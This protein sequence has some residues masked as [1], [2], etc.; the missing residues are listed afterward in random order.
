MNDLSDTR[1]DAALTTF[2]AMLDGPNPPNVEQFL[3]RYPDIAEQLGPLLASIAAVQG[4]GRNCEPAEAL[5][6]GGQI[7]P[8]RLLREIGRGGMG[9]V[10][11]AED[12]AMPRRVAVKVVAAGLLDAASRAALL[13]E[14]RIA[15]VLQHPNIVP[16][17]AAGEVDGVA[18]IAMQYIDGRPLSAV[19]RA[20]RIDA[21]LESAV[22]ASTPADSSLLATGL[23]TGFGAQQAPSMVPTASVTVD[24]TYIREIAALGI[25]AAN[26]L[27]FV[28][29]NGVL[30][31]DAKPGNF[32]LDVRGHLWLSD[33]GLARAAMK[34]EETLGARVGTLRYASPEQSTGGPLDPRSDLYA[35][36]VTLYELLTL[37]PAFAGDDPRLLA[38][39]QDDEPVSLR[40]FA[41][42]VPVDLATVI[43]KAMAKR[44]YDRYPSAVALAADLNRFLC[45]EHVE[46]R[47]LSR[48][49]R[50]GRLAY[51]RRRPFALAIA[52]LFIGLSVAGI[53]AWRGYRSEAKARQE[54][55]NREA[56][57]RELV[58]EVNKSEAVFRHL[59]NGQPEHRRLVKVLKEVV[60]RWADEPNA[61]VET[62]TEAVRACLRLGQVEMNAGQNIEGGAT[63][64][65]A[66][67]RVSELRAVDPNSASLRFLHAQGLQ[68]RARVL[69]R[70]P[71]N[72][73]AGSLAAA[74][75]ATRLLEELIDEFPERTEYRNPIGHLAT[76]MANL[77]IDQKRYA[78]A[79]AMMEKALQSDQ[80][81][82]NR[83]PT[84]HP[85]SYIRLAGTWCG[86]AEARY[87]S[88]DL[89]GAE[90]AYREA[91]RNDQILCEPRF[92]YPRTNR[93][94]TFA[95]RGLFGRFLIGQ[96]RDADARPYIEEFA[97]EAE[98]FI[99]IYPDRFVF[100]QHAQ[101]AYLDLGTLEYLAGR[102]EEARRA[103]RKSL[104]FR[105]DQ[106]REEATTLALLSL[107][108]PLDDLRESEKIVKA[109][110][111]EIGHTTGVDYR[112]SRLRHAIGTRDLAGARSLRDDLINRAPKEPQDRLRFAF[113]QA[114]LAG[115]AGN[116]DVAK[117]H[118][119]EAERILQ[120]EPVPVNA[121]YRVLR[122]ETELL[123][124]KYAK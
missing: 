85:Q 40:L 2:A 58:S 4:L 112:V 103:Y 64:D 34:S 35:L 87:L 121:E 101:E 73:H 122:R 115:I 79:V 53:V 92:A 86:L 26:A 94:S 22:L 76:T 95:I 59:P 30:H 80:W 84:G 124:Q 47:P 1:L 97:R 46:A 96:N 29:D 70:E 123:I 24:G 107:W 14:A 75:E 89:A 49:Q 120:S 102:T 74:T 109:L 12:K 82:A 108:I 83:Y 43:H 21:G 25:Q 78:D 27:A 72:D 114:Q 88:G 33:F 15:A 55:E 39:I 62:R 104:L 100:I 51:R 18:Y 60:C 81:L 54:L 31:R 116:S 65:E 90:A 105:P 17:L 91:L 41:P 10:Y 45:G 93:E 110:E 63:F 16:V 66:I 32:L 61:T 67:R 68:Y 50:L 98:D 117:S 36:G 106:P 13:R 113:L 111:M 69:M 3:S 5:S 20:R 7:G 19:I 56:I 9:I 23:S 6:H 99:R 11:E 38:R 52:M 57:L 37:H 71:V 77:L 48:W 8:Y 119:A 42:G 118:L 28:H 44:P